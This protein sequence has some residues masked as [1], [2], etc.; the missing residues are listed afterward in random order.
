MGSAFGFG[1]VGGSAFHF[2]KGL[3]NSPGGHRLAGACRAVRSN[4]PRIGGIFAVWSGLFSAFDCTLVYAR[5]KEDLWNSIAA[6]AATGGLL[7]MRQGLRAASRSALSCGFFLALIEGNRIWLNKIVPAQQDMPVVIEDKNPN[8][9]SETT[10]SSSSSFGGE[11]EEEEEAKGFTTEVL[12]SF[13]SPVPST[14]E[15]K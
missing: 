11:E 15:F 7:Q 6:G 10:T 3:C 4:A 5:Q 13:D 2:I 9:S 8:K 1:A 12:E 14:S